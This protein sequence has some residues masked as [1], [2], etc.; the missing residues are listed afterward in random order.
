MDRAAIEIA[1]GIT[2][3]LSR[4]DE[5]FSYI[6]YLELPAGKTVKQIGPWEELL[7][8]EDIVYA[9]ISLR[10]GDIIANITDSGKRPGFVLVKGKSRTEV[11]KKPSFTAGNF[12]IIYRL[13][14]FYA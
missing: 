4:T 3:T 14:K 7:E 8:K 5:T 1:L 12:K 6:K 2:P 13:I 9:N 11:F 10:K